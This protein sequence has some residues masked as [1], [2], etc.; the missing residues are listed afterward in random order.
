MSVLPNRDRQA[1]RRESTR[2]EIVDA[3]WAEASAV[4]LASITLRN[5]AAR[6]G[7]QAPSLY[8][9]FASKN[10][11]YDAMFGDAWGAYNAQVGAQRTR[12]TA[13]T[14]ARKR[15]LLM[16]EGYFDYAV[17]NLERYQ[18]MNQRTIPDFTPTDAAYAESLA[19][20]REMVGQFA[21]MGV[22]RS[23]DVDVYTALIAGLIDQ[24]LA[25]D[26]DGDRWRRQLARVMD[27]FADDLGLPGPTLTRRTK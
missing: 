21:A 18:L 11:I 15:L 2:R 22:T 8:S 4:G 19:C 24:Q 27:M 16:A 23:E 26:R 17:Q 14:S 20:Y 5:I 13:R 25:N 10:A 12:L 7:M 3:A 9:H 6:V 1:E